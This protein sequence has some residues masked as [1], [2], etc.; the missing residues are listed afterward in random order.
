RELRERESTLRYAIIDLNLAKTDVPDSPRK[1]GRKNKDLEFQ[2]AELETSLAELER[3]R[4]E[5]FAALNA[6]LK[7]TRDRL[8]KLEHAMAVHYR[9][10]YAELDEVRTSIIT[11]ESRNL[12]RR[13]ER[14]RAALAQ[15]Q[16]PG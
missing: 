12:Y 3:Q 8:K 6:E 13:L 11:Q 16:S 2:I 1:G 15:S 10:L 5:R 4:R 9:R 14:C 7:E